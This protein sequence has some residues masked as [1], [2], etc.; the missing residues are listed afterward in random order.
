MGGSVGRDLARP[1]IGVSKPLTPECRF[2]AL[3]PQTLKRADLRC[4]LRQNSAVVTA[5]ASELEEPLSS[6]P[7][8]NHHRAFAMG[9]SRIAIYPPH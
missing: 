3:I 1:L 2:S 5:A 8:G 4:R 6:A 9:S 7:V